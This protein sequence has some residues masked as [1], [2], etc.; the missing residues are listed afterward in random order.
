MATGTDRPLIC[1]WQHQQ[2]LDLAP[3]QA[4]HFN[5]LWTDDEPYHGQSW[6]QTHM[7][8]ALQVPGIR[9]VIP[10]IE[11]LQWGQTHEGSLKHAA[12]IGGLAHQHPEI[13]GLYLNDF[14][15]E[16][17]DGYRTM[18][19]WREII[20]AVRA[21]NP[22]LP[23]WVPHYPHRGNERQPYDFDYQGVIFNIWDPENIPAAERYLQQAEAK[24]A[25]KC[26]VG[27]LYLDS[28]AR[29]GH[30]LAEGEFRGL[31]GL[32]L[33]HTLSGELAGLRI[34]CACQLLQRPEYVRWAQEVLA[35]LAR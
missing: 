19:Q 8:R 26:I 1:L 16:I 24:H 22:A 14:Y 12:W 23:L 31:L 15:D 29:G 33:E 3:L 4:L 5:V 27:S 9:Q 20:A 34:F 10:K 13:M 6:E 21:V 32:F 28:G 11:R 7:F 35:P 2:G 30:W 25:D 18:M 17:E